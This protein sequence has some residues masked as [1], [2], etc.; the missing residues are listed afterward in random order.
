M[1]TGVSSNRDTGTKVASNSASRASAKIKKNICPEQAIKQNYMGVCWLTSPRLPSNKTLVNPDRF[2]GNTCTSH[3]HH[4]K[5]YKPFS[6]LNWVLF[7]ILFTQVHV[8][9]AG[10][11]TDADTGEGIEGAIISVAGINKNMTSAEFGDYWRLL[12]PGTY[13]ITVH[14]KGCVCHKKKHWCVKITGY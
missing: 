1:R 9:V 13:T 5:F 4:I 12:V 6:K 8:G 10:F 7:I 2:E 11:I 3:L 14:A